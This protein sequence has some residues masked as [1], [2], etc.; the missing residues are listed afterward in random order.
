MRLIGSQLCF[1]INVLGT[2]V[3][4]CGKHKNTE[5][6]LMCVKKCFSFD[7]QN[8]LKWRIFSTER[9]MIVTSLFGERSSMP[10]KSFVQHVR[11]RQQ[12]AIAMLTWEN[13][14]LFWR[15]AVCCLFRHSLFATKNHPSRETGANTHKSNE[16]TTATHQG[17]ASLGGQHGLGRPMHA[18]TLSGAQQHDAQGRQ[19]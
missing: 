12:N 2:C 16:A 10:D 18:P 4:M 1:S 3:S 11:H 17:G 9:N 13:I 6:F 8:I 14:L 15:S 7:C 5:W 19:Q